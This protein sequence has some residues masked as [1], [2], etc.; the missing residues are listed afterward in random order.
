MTMI[1]KTKNKVTQLMVISL[2][3]VG[4]LV[5]LS[6][7]SEE[8]GATQRIG[9]DATRDATRIG[10]FAA[11]TVVA[12]KESSNDYEK[13]LSTFVLDIN[14]NQTRNQGGIINNPSGTEPNNQAGNIRIFAKADCYSQ[15]ICPFLNL[16]I[17]NQSLNTWF[18]G[19]QDS[20][21]YFDFQ[22]G[23]EISSL[24]LIFP[25]D[26]YTPLIGDNNLYIDH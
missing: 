1:S 26:E 3:M 8:T 10:S 11:I 22:Y 14:P 25:N 21:Q 9:S 18:V 5:P 19:N 15:N 23:S 2:L 6:L 4:L 16:R 17:N 13:L 20:Y 7:G 24:D 12:Q